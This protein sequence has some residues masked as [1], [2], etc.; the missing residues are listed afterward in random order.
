M[1]A[2]VGLLISAE[3]TYVDKTLKNKMVD[4]WH[5]WLVYVSYHK[6]KTITNKAMLKGLS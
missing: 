3:S 5:A 2:E 4:L 6:L 1:T